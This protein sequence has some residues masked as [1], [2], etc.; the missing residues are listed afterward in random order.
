MNKSLILIF[1]LLIPGLM[2]AQFTV[3]STVPV[4]LSKNVPLYTTISIT[5]SEALDT[6]AMNDKSEGTW[7]SNI[8]SIASYGYSTDQKTSYVNVV[9]K[10]NT[11]YFLAFT[12]AKA[13]SG[14]IMTTPHVYY[15]TTGAD[16]SPY[17]VSGTISPGTMNISPEGSVVALSKIDFMNTDI[18]GTPP[19]GGWANVNSNGTFTVPYV[20]NGK[21]WPLVAKDVNGDGMINP[22]SDGDLIV[23]G[24]SIIVNNAS[25]SGLAM[26]FFSI[27][28]VQPANLATNV[29]LNTTFS[30]TFSEPVDTVALN[31]NGDNW[32]TNLDSMVSYGYS[33]DL[34]TAWSTHVLKPN[35]TYFVAFSYIKARSGAVI[36]KPHVYYF[37]TGSALEPASVSGT[38]SSGSTGVSPEG[39]VVGL[40][41]IDFM[42]QNTEGPP[43]FGGWSNVNANGT[44][45]IPYVA[46]G[47]Y[48]PL[49]IKDVDHD[50][51]YKP[52]Q[53]VDVMAVGDSIVVNNGSISGVS[54]TFFA[55]TPKTFHQVYQT[56]ESLAAAKLPVDRSLRKISAWDVDSLG[57]ASS[58]EFAYTINGNT[59]G[60]IVR[61]GTMDNSVENMDPNYFQWV[62]T[63]KPLTGYQLAASSATVIA[64]TEAAGG[65]QVRW[66]QIP[67]AWEFRIELSMS[68]QKNGW[69][70]PFGI[71]TSK[72]YWAAAYAYNYQISENQGQWMGGKLFLC[73]LTTGVVLK[74]QDIYMGV[75]RKPILPT[76]NTLSQN[77]PN[78]F[79][80]TTTISFS[81]PSAGV[82]SLKVFD[83]LGREVAILVNEKKDAGQY[84]V[85][86]DASARASG[87][88]FYTLQAGTFRETKRM[89]LIK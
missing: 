2:L 64:N 72:I 50:G 78:P 23:M 77:Y 21:Y 47:T 9:L 39:A 5:F 55:L 24:D 86:W 76:E 11:N 61:V 82:T 46:N 85:Q 45:T 32:F 29:P 18:D 25:V 14:A 68:D 87:I 7:F 42:N 10:P 75:D 26:T 1:V 58:W 54:L 66:K 38:V 62:S 81:I 84:S 35:K 70:N 83:L 49:A 65:K 74:T 34:K 41:K 56:A 71:D 59:T 20:T 88:Y 36:T 63:M 28:S 4:N 60:K 31:E 79:N 27:M 15:F 33:K 3:I 13:K 69:F 6:V 44:F 16:F 8:D 80:P 51:Q 37:T 89:L 43:P 19:F 17:S 52:E 40:S 57:R 12:F 73:D 67:D 22:G 53:G 48:W 30:I